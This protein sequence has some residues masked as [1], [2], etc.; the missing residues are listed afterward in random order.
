MGKY[1]A[2][3]SDTKSR[4]VIPAYDLESEEFL[5]YHTAGN[6]LR[7]RS[8]EGDPIIPGSVADSHPTKIR[9]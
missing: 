3:W 2:V 8:G 9:I 7:F 6:V 1:L 5:R 4:S